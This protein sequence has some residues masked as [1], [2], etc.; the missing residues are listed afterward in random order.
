MTVDRVALIDW[1]A[2]ALAGTYTGT[3]G[4]G[5][6]TI[7]VARAA[8]GL[9]I[10]INGA[11]AQPLAWVEGLTFRHGGILLTFRR[12]NGGG[13]PVTGLRYDTGTEHSI[14]ARS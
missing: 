5:P 4:A 2:E 6:T 11:A 7:Q 3:T 14:L 1:D 9:T 12:A 8:E 10:S 13:G